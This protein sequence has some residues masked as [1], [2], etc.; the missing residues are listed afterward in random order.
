MVHVAPHPGRESLSTTIPIFLHGDGGP[1]TKKSSAQILH[2][3]SCEW[4]AS[5]SELETCFMIA[6]WVPSGSCRNHEI[7]KEIRHSLKALHNGR[8]P[9]KDANGNEFP[10]KSFQKMQ[11]GKLLAG[12]WTAVFIMMRG[13]LDYLCNELRLTHYG[14]ALPCGLCRC[15]RGGELQWNHL[16]LRAGWLNTVY[17]H[18]QFLNMY[19]GEHPIHEFEG[20]GP[21]TFAVDLLHVVDNNG[22]ASHIL[23]N[24]FYEAIRNRELGNRSKEQGLQ[25]LNDRI[26]QFYRANPTPAQLQSLAMTNLIDDRNE[27]DSFPILHG[28]AVKAANTRYIIPFAAQLATEL[29]RGTDHQRHR[30]RCC[31]ELQRFYD[32]IHGAGQF[33]KPEEVADLKSATVKC[34][35]HYVW[36]S[37]EAVRNGEMAWNIVPKH[38]YMMHIGLRAAYMNPCCGQTYINES[39]VGRVC[40]MYSST[41][42]GTGDQKVVQKSVLVKYLTGLTVTFAAR[43]G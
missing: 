16:S 3:G 30:Q 42:A 9:E 35:Q 18:Q 32:I 43:S 10:N 27:R 28:K 23:G 36:M 29:N 4:H 5:G 40:T 41:M 37:K 2:W 19:R 24:L 13:D 20:C 39:M 14:S 11:A 38:H 34:L 12:G 6:S 1:I 7:W 33:L 15:D 22:V 21:M 26:K 25:M 17:D 31:A 8:F